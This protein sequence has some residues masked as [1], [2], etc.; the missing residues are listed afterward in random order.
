MQMEMNFSGN[1][2]VPLDVFWEKLFGDMHF[3]VGISILLQTENCTFRYGWSLII[4][5]QLLIFNIYLLSALPLMSMLTSCFLNNLT[6]CSD[7]II[8]KQASM[9]LELTSNLV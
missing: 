8:E 4:H 6:A 1:R 5:F 2:S 9:A 3:H 7:K